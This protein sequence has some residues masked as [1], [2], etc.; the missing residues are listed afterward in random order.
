M[1][2]TASLISPSFGSGR[3]TFNP[4]INKNHSFSHPEIELRPSAL[5]IQ[6][7]TSIA[8]A[9]TTLDLLEVY[10]D[11]VNWKER[12]DHSS[13]L[14]YFQVVFNVFKFLRS[15]TQLRRAEDF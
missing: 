10:S 7:R 3:V 13:L 15:S 11:H 6:P 4:A 12:L 8:S 2:T 14:K 9:T 5:N 1:F